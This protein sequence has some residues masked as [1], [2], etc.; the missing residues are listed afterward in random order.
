MRVPAKT[1]IN[2]GNWESC[3]E[4][5]LYN[6]SHVKLVIVRHDFH[7]VEAAISIPKSM[8]FE[9]VL[10]G[11]YELALLGGVYGFGGSAIG[12]RPPAPHLHEH[13]RVAIARDKIDLTAP[14]SV[15]GRNDP[16]PAPAKLRRG[17]NLSL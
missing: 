12:G 1:G 15:I 16:V 2:A 11:E 13:Q 14:A 7:Y 8:L 9:V 5:V 6:I 3:G 4:C 17:D 10:S